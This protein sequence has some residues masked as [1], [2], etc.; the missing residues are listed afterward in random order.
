MS[1][2]DDAIRG[3]R[4]KKLEKS[5]QMLLGELAAHL[6][7]YPEHAYVRFSN[8]ECPYHLH[9]WRGIYAELAIDHSPIDVFTTVAALLRM[10]KEATQPGHLFEGYK[11]GEYQM[12]RGT[13]VWVSHYGDAEHYG[14][15][16][17]HDSGDGVVILELAEFEPY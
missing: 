16:D 15:T 12:H 14:I 3:Q 1:S 8:G 4:A 5:N 9:S 17:V 6:S 2:V 7:M 13:P 10:L 11:G